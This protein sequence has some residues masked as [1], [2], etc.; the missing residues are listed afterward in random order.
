MLQGRSAAAI[1]PAPADMETRS[2][3]GGPVA[4]DEALPTAPSGV[5]DLH[6]GIWDPPRIP[7]P[8]NGRGCLR[9]PEHQRLFCEQT[10]EVILGRCKA[11]N[12]CPYCRLL[13]VVE[14]A[15]MLLLDAM[16]FAPS[17]L[18][19]LTAREHL[20]RCDTHDHLRQVLRA[21]RKRWPVEWHVQVEFQKRGALHLHHLVKGVPLDDGDRFLQLV[22][23]VWCGRLDA[24]PV[25]QSV[26]EITG[27]D[28]LVRYLQK[29]LAHGLKKEQAP[30]IGWKGHRTSQ[31]RGYLV[32]PASQMREEARASLRLDR[33][34]WRAHQLGYEGEDAAVAAQ[35]ELE[36]R[37][38]LTWRL[39]AIDP[40]AH[41]AS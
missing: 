28:G 23:R 26:R 22:T 37:A 14:T 1:F 13:A 34:L 29:E 33:A 18:L 2:E 15:E 3:P 7:D 40:T 10:G 35:E 4:P 25:A 20:T 21:A 19:T 27:A 36:Q 32:R 24:E 9:W 5:L 11:T 41:A 16:E 38:E 6:K 17:L 12:L 30:P 39:R 8:R 31:T